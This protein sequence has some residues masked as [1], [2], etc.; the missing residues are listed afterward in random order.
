VPEFRIPNISFNAAKICL[1]YFIKDKSANNFR[2]L[3]LI[4]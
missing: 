1:F 4:N 2:Y 3:V